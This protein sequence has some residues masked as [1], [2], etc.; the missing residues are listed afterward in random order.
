MLKLRA[1]HK[2]I[3]DYYLALDMY[4]KHGMTHETAIRNAFQALLIYS[5]KQMKLDFIE[6]FPYIR[7]NKHKARIDG[8]FI[9]KFTVPQGYWEAKDSQDDLA[10]EVVK[11]FELGY[12]KDNIIFQSPE[13]AIIYQG[14]TLVFDEDIS[15]PQR[16]V[17]A[18]KVLFH[19]KTDTQHDWEKAV[20]EFKQRIPEFAEQVIMLIEEERINNAPF[21]SSLKNFIDLCKTSI[22]PNISNAAIDEMLVQHLL[23]ERIFRKVFENPD[24]VNR[25]I[26]AYEIDKVIS[27][28]TSRKFN[29]NEF[30]RPLD[31]FYTVLEKRAAAI[32]DYSVKQTFLNTVYEKFFQGF[33]VKV[34][35]THGIVYTPQ[36]IVDFMV[37]SVEEVL[38]REF[39]RSL[40]SQNVHILDPFTGTGNFIVNIMRKINKTDLKHKYLNELHCN[41]IM[42]MPYYVASM[43]IEHQFYELTGEYLPFPGICLVDTFQLAE[44]ID[45]PLF[46]E[47]NTARVEKQ[48]NTPIFV[49]IGNPP[50]NAGQ[51]N[52]NDNN[53]NRKYPV[54]DKRVSD[55]F[56]KESKATLNNQLYDPY[57]KAY[58]FAMDKMKRLDEG[59]IAFITNHSFID[60]IA[61]DGMRKHL[62]ESFD[63][64]YIVDLGGNVRKSNNKKI[65]NVFDIMVGVSINILVK[66][67]KNE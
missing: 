26:I 7:L 14:A 3:K 8:A 48:K 66:K 15:S 35:D 60:G 1:N 64:V 63:K 41:E 33:A 22:N 6:E 53:K 58:L 24:F 39:N 28:L 37:N 19:Y 11:K 17:D 51:A 55:T 47:E 54:I 18:L 30:L 29:R 62:E 43:N 45:Q 52:E 21:N 16:L 20:E 44:E 61:F 34:A 13:R 31:R 36:P 25:N 23:T 59:I 65:S 38:K 10:K 40:S 12:P 2:Q 46:S 27:A 57:V 42:L 9:D 56:V 67:R 49:Y 32:D 50:Y 4:S 5:C